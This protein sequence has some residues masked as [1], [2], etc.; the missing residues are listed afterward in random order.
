MHPLE[1]KVISFIKE[2]KL[3]PPG[4]KIV[5]G[6]SGGPDS[7]FLLRFLNKYKQLFKISL[8]CAH[9]NHN[10]RG[11]NSDADEKFCRTPCLQFGIELC[12]ESVNVKSLAKTKKISV[13]EA[14]RM[15][16]YD[17][18]LSVCKENNCNLIATAHTK[19][20]NAETV[21]LNL[22]KGSGL[23]GLGGIPLKRDNIIRPILCLEKEELLEYLKTNKLKY[24]VDKSN[25]SNDFQRNF[26][27]NKIIPLIK[28]INPNFSGN[29]LNQSF[30]LREASAI[31][32]ASGNL[33]KRKYISVE[34]GSLTIKTKLFEEHSEF[35]TG[36]IIRDQIKELFTKPISY[37]NTKEIIYLSEK[38]AG[39]R[40]S[41]PGSLIAT[42]ER[43]NIVISFPE[44]FREEQNYI[45][46]GEKISIANRT[47]CSLEVSK[48]KVTVSGDKKTEFID[49]DKLPGDLFTLRHWL[50]GD[51]FAPIGLKGRKK[52]SDFLTDVKVSSIKRKE[53]L[54]LLN[55]GKIVW[56]VGHRLDDRFKITNKTKRFLQL[57]IR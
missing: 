5:V 35:I 4:S 18:F 41:L 36:E 28:K 24:R 54:V 49:L 27:R 47:F 3:I 13:E 44:T 40:I 20:D 19:D 29:T 39:T 6:F 50:P 12:V 38:Q 42:R 52:V 48:A 15:A 45:P 56:L 33:L 8:I 53:N 14:A 2:N 10:L 51:S 57:T 21:L 26:V 32:N 9:V 17:F 37:I 34:K 1:E 7:L 16:R 23:A 31:F 46:I 22:I 30:L 55:E 11:K 43:N 25:Y